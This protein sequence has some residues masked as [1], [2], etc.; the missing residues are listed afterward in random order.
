MWRHARTSPS[1][2]QDR[3]L[4]PRGKPRH[5]DA[6]SSRPQSRWV[7]FSP[8]G[9][10]SV[11]S[12]SPMVQR[13]Q[14]QA[15]RVALRRRQE[16]FRGRAARPSQAR[17]QAPRGLG[18][19]APGRSPRASVSPSTKWERA[20]PPAPARESCEDHGAAVP[21]ACGTRRARPQ[22]LTRLPRT[23]PAPSVPC[24]H[25]RPESR[26]PSPVQSTGC[27]VRA[28]S[29]SAS[30]LRPP[31]HR[32]RGRLAER[33]RHHTSAQLG[34]APSPQ[35]AWPSLPKAFLTLA[36]WDS[37]PQTRPTGQATP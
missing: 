37:K 15:Q 1:P 35:T 12:P 27:H 28:G 19:A 21:T 22:P 23:F 9:G 36:A 13:S 29:G 4:V 7:G 24:T 34:T 8:P 20:P 30:P 17:A 25:T 6:P 31:A 5:G 18:C 26:A 32:Y 33:S 14:G 16:C 3:H 10:L 2:R 11:V